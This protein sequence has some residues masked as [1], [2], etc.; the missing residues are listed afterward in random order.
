MTAEGDIPLGEADFR[1]ER[2]LLSPSVFFW[3]NGEPGS[4]PAPIDPITAE[5]WRDVM[6]LATHVVLYTTSQDGSRISRLKQL[7]SDWV[8]SWP[9]P[10]VAPFVEYPALVAGEEFD[11][12]VFNALHGYYRQAIGCLRVA[13][14]TLAIAAAF[15]VRGDLS[16]FER[17]QAGDLEGSFGTARTAL[18][19]SVDG[20]RIDATT[21]PSSVFGDSSDS[22][23]KARYRRLCDYAHSRAGYD[24]GALWRSNGPIYVAQ[25]LGTVE[26]EFRE[27]MALC[28]LL[29]RIGWDGYEPGPGQPALLGGP[30]DGWAQYATM[31]REWLL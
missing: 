8:F 2:R 21:A 12:A 9:Q 11:A 28:Y 30:L 18:G 16:S 19:D 20:R 27:T 1:R 14:E 25:A 17:W 29:A 24:N 5:V 7:E 15:S 26:C 22:W 31:L 3:A 13:L 6:R 10:G 23:M 4:W